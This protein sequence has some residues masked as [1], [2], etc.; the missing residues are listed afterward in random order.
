MA[1]D[2]GRGLVIAF[3][4]PVEATLGEVPCASIFNTTT[5]PALGDQAVCKWASHRHLVARLG[6][7]SSFG[8]ISGLNSVA[9]LET[10][11]Q[12][13][14]TSIPVIEHW[15][16]PS[17]IAGISPYLDIA[18]EDMPAVVLH[19]PVVGSLCGNAA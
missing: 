5:L 19:A 16:Y 12:H 1:S 13:L 6:F 15:K 10:A 2:A 4:A 11:L 14:N 18:S 3:D 7:G 8:L 17:Q 9:I